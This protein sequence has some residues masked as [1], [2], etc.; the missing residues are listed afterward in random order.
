MGKKGSGS[1]SSSSVIPLIMTDKWGR[2][3]IRISSLER[4]DS[5]RGK[6]G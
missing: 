1:S 4:G 2:G 6:G 5:S 3:S